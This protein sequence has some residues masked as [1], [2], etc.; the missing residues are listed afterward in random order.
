MTLTNTPNDEW[1]QS[2][3]ADNAARVIGS[4]LAKSF[5]IR[6]CSWEELLFAMFWA[7]WMKANVDASS[8]GDDNKLLLLAPSLLLSA[9]SLA[10]ILVL[11]LLL[12]GEPL[13]LRC[14]P[15]FWERET[16]PAERL[17]R[18]K[19]GV[20]L[21]ALLLLV[22]DESFVLSPLETPSEWTWR[23]SMV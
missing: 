7:A 1:E 9:A 2:P 18:S 8:L 13:L 5:T 4:L 6:C 10:R 20:V 14:L 12:E 15:L 21:E 23:L 16:K 3:N 11:P 19:L 17:M 22:L